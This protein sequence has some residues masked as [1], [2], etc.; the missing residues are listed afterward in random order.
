M[1]LQTAQV[2]PTEHV[3]RADIL[4]G[5]AEQSTFANANRL[6]TRTVA[7]Y[8]NRPNGLPWLE[9]AGRVYIPLDEAAAWLREQVR[10][11][12]RRRA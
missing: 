8:R 2:S 4:A 10:R 5:Y 1:T 7:R 11:P 3:G 9:F 12:N 6:S